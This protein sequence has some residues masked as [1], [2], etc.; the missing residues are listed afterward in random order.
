MADDELF[1]EISKELIDANEYAKLPPFHATIFEANASRIGLLGSDLAGA[2]TVVYTNY[3]VRSEI[4]KQSFEMMAKDLPKHFAQQIA[5]GE[6]FCEDCGDIERFLIEFEKTGR[7]VSL[8]AEAAGFRRKQKD[9][10][11]PSS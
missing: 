3:R 4:F 10:R 7:S 9:E 2:T 1:R 6:K 8:A 5:W 11:K